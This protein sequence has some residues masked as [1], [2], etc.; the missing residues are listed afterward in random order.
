MGGFSDGF[1]FCFWCLLACFSNLFWQSFSF[2]ETYID[3]WAFLLE[4]V[5]LLGFAFGVVFCFWCLLV[6]SQTHSGSCSFGVFVFF[7]GGACFEGFSHGWMDLYWFKLS[8]LSREFFDVVE[9]NVMLKLF[10]LP[11]VPF[12]FAQVCLFLVYLVALFC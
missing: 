4:R 7:L 12:C 5:F 9:F 6:V 2:G 1:C 11:L 3:L 10:M 8:L